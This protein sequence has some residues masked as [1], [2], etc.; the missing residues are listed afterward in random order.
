VDERTVPLN[1]YVDSRPTWSVDVRYLVDGVPMDWTG[2]TGKGVMVQP[3]SEPRDLEV[4]FPATSTTWPGDVGGFI[5]FSM[6]GLDE[7]PGG[8]YDYQVV[9]KPALGPE[10]IWSEGKLVQPT[11]WMDPLS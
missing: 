8:S 10:W 6:S 2:Y 3:G 7:V 5:R 4:S 9:V 11:Y 1:L